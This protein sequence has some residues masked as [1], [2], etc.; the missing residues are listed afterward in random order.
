MCAKL[1][2]VTLSTLPRAW[3]R[4]P[5]KKPFAHHTQVS[6]MIFAFLVKIW[7][8]LHRGRV[9][10]GSGTNTV[11]CGR[12]RGEVIDVRFPHSWGSSRYEKNNPYRDIKKICG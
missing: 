10:P 8:C 6:F 3:P 12:K 1:K 2:T 9:F 4:F 5:K 11:E 7:G